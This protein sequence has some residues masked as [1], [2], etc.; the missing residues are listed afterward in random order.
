MRFDE[1]S[2]GVIRLDGTDIRALT[3]AS[4][5]RQIAY[6]GQEVVLFHATLAENIAYGRPGATRDAIL[7]AARAAHVDEFLDRLPQ[8]IDTPVGEKGLL[9][10]GGQRQ[11]VAIA[12]ALLKDA[13]ILVLDEA[14]AALDSQS[15]GHIQAAIEALT[16]ARTTL[17][18]AH[19]LS[20]IERA[21]RIVVLDEGR[22]VET[23]TH[24]QL[25]A[26]RGAYAALHRGHHAAASGPE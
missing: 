10:S 24:A 12:R 1:A 15:E 20:T 7:A 21:D 23:G 4:L 19:R 22:I 6:V 5:R 26:R 8:G 14:T 18:I 9:L 13:P 2:A 25:L 16:A 11:R 17:V 3:L